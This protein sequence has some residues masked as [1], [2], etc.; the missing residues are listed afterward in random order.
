MW[1]DLKAK[2]SVEIRQKKKQ[3]ALKTKHATELSAKEQHIIVTACRA[4][5]GTRSQWDLY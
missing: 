1:S 3:L 4:P 2:K 5:Q